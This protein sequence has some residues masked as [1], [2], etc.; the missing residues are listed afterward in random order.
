MYCFGD[1]ETTYNGGKKFNIFP[2]ILGQKESR[3][4]IKEL[5]Y[6]IMFCGSTGTNAVEAALK[7][8]RKNKKSVLKIL[9]IC[10]SV[11]FCLILLL[12]PSKILGNV[13]FN[14]SLPKY[15]IFSNNVSLLSESNISRLL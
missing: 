14:S 1:M 15:D 11:L 8:A 12:V 5:D 6:K 7:L 9:K 13:S 4:Y 2:T 3:K 10:Y